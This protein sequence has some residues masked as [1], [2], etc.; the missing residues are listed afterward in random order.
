MIIDQST[1]NFV[2]SAI[3]SKFWLQ[4]SQTDHRLETLK[5]KKIDANKSRFSI[6]SQKTLT[7]LT[8]FIIRKSATMQRRVANGRDA[9]SD[10]LTTVSE[11]FDAK[12]DLYRAV[13]AP[14]ID[15]LSIRNQREMFLKDSALHPKYVRKAANDL[16]KKTE[17]SAREGGLRVINHL[18]DGIVSAGNRYRQQPCASR[19]LQRVTILKEKEDM[20]ENS[21]MNKRWRHQ[22]TYLRVVTAEIEA[23][24]LIYF[25]DHGLLKKKKIAKRHLITRNHGLVTF[26]RFSER[27]LDIARHLA[28]A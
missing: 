8:G 16:A 18:K 25:I 17:S 14:L 10:S 21:Y 23:L 20:V 26:S 7:Q 28:V 9:L 15:H 3:N 4:K 11:I 27:N 12:I 19:R 24:A 6:I 22:K 5:R 1:S 2:N 13:R